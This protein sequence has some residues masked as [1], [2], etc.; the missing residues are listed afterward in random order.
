MDNSEFSYIDG[1]TNGYIVENVRKYAK[2]WFYDVHYNHDGKLIEYLIDTGVLPRFKIGKIGADKAISYFTNNT[3][4]EILLKLNRIP[5][6]VCDIICRY[7][8]KVSPEYS[9][10]IYS[11]QN[12][13]YERQYFPDDLYVFRGYRCKKEFI[14]LFKQKYDYVDC[15][16]LRGI[17]R[18]IENIE[19][20]KYN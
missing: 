17:L 8:Y 13:S 16:V 19:V 6:R 9:P 1:F 10:Y 2:G 12:T 5:N 11:Y 20:R 15:D 7:D 18:V 14:R 4:V 3:Y